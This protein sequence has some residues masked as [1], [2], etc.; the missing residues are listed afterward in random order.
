MAQTRKKRRT[1]HR[2]NAAGMVEARGRT[3]RKPTDD[4]RKLNSKDEARQRRVERM[5]RPP[6]WRGALNRSLIATGIFFVALVVAF[7]EP[8]PRALALSAVVAVFYVPMGYYTDKLIHQ[9][10]RSRKAQ[11]G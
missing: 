2:G 9:R 5:N 3:G 7:H 11:G 6:S 4:E 1:K 10:R 8:V